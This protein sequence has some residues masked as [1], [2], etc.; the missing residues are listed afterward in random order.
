M[1]YAYGDD[2]PSK[3]AVPTSLPVGE[4]SRISSVPAAPARRAVS[5]EAPG[6]S[7]V[8]ANFSHAPSAVADTAV[9][10]AFDSSTRLTAP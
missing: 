6:P 5:V 8:S 7:R 4:P 2:V 1:S 10:L 3:R 9:P